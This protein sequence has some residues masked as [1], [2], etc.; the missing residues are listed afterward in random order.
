MDVDAVHVL[1]LGTLYFGRGI[2]ILAVKLE[3]DFLLLDDAKVLSARGDDLGKQRRLQNGQRY[4][5]RR[6]QEWYTQA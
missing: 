6:G 2:Q 1:N 5:E 3:P 4:N